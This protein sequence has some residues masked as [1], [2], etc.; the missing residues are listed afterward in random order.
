[1]VIQWLKRTTGNFTALLF[2]LKQD[3]QDKLDRFTTV[4]PVS[5]TTNAAM[6]SSANDTK[7]NFQ[8]WE[9]SPWEVVFFG[10]RYPLCVELYWLYT[11]EQHGILF[12]VLLHEWLC[13][14]MYTSMHEYLRIKYGCIPQ[15]QKVFVL[16]IHLYD[17]YNGYMWT[18]SSTH[19]DSWTSW[20]WKRPCASG[21]RL[22]TKHKSCSS[23]WIGHS[24]D[25]AS[26]LFLLLSCYLFFVG[27]M[28]CDI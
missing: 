23:L 10:L 9:K 5:S 13:V 15:A 20:L 25:K 7:F 12:F 2:T 8:Y 11:R 3:L 21:P 19:V 28:L 27:L 1:M 4:S 17:I 14:Q 18:P 22:G 24:N 6:L 16:G 26:F